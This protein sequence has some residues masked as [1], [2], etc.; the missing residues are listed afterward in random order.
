MQG[1]AL[2]PG[3]WCCLPVAC[4]S[5]IVGAGCW[6]FWITPIWGWED[7]SGPWHCVPPLQWLGW[8]G[9]GSLLQPAF[10]CI[11]LSFQVKKP[12]KKQ[13]SELSRKPNQKEKRGR[14][15][16]KPRNKSASLFPALSA[17]FFWGQISSAGAQSL[18]RTP[19]SGD[20]HLCGAVCDSSTHGGI[21]SLHSPRSKGADGGVWRALG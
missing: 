20:E 10:A 16:E 8:G 12:T 21:S 13:P 7:Q 5:D 9:G 17:L 6:I 3:Q 11:V 2:H 19:W 14:A 15:E 18:L 1:T 4:T